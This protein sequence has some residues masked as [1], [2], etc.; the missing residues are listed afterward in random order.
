MRRS[1][2]KKYTSILLICVMLFCMVLQNA[3]AFDISIRSRNNWA[4]ASNATSSNWATASNSDRFTEL[5]H[6]DV[7]MTASALSTGFADGDEVE[8][9]VYLTNR[10]DEVVYNGRLTALHDHVYDEDEEES[11]N[12]FTEIMQLNENGEWEEPEFSEELIGYETIGIT[13]SELLGIGL[14]AG[15]TYRILY[16]YCVEAGKDVAKAD[17]LEFRFRGETDSRKVNANTVLYHNINGWNLMPDQEVYTVMAGQNT[18]ITVNVEGWEELIP[19]EEAVLATASDAT[20][21]NAAAYSAAMMDTLSWHMWADAPLE[22]VEWK[23]NEDGTMT[24]HFYVPEDIAA[25]VYLTEVGAKGV[26]G[27]QLYC[28]TEA[29]VLLVEGRPELM[30]RTYNYEDDEIIVDAELTSFNR[31]ALPIGSELKADRIT[32]EAELAWIA[33]KVQN[34]TGLVYDVAHAYDIRFEF[35]G[36]EIEPVDA[37][38]KVQI[39]YKEALTLNQAAKQAEAEDVKVLHL[40]SEDTVE[41]VTEEIATNTEGDVEAASFETTSFSIFVLTQPPE[42]ANGTF[43]Q[44]EDDSITVTATVD[45]TAGIPE[46][47]QLVLE[48]IGEEDVRYQAAKT[49]LQALAATDENAKTLS[50]GDLLLYDFYFQNVERNKLVLGKDIELR[51]DFVYKTDVELG[52][53]AYGMSKQGVAGEATQ[54]TVPV[55]Q[56]DID[57]KIT[58]VEGTAITDKAAV[59]TTNVRTYGTGIVVTSRAAYPYSEETIFTQGGNYSLYYILNNFN[60]FSKGNVASGHCI[61][62]AAVGGT[63]IFSAGN[64]KDTY[65]HTAPTYLEG[66]IETILDGHM[67]ALYVGEINANGGFTPQGRART[68]ISKDNRYIDFDEAFKQIEA[69]A[70]SLAYSTGTVKVSQ[71]DVETMKKAVSTSAWANDIVREHYTIQYFYGPSRMVGVTVDDG[72]IYEFENLSDIGM[73]NV[74]GNSADANAVFVDKSSGKRKLPQIH[75]KGS[76]TLNGIDGS[77][78]VGEGFG[79][80]FV[81]PNATEIDCSGAWERWI[82]HIVAPNAIVSGMIGD[83]NGATICKEYNNPGTECHMWP[84]KGNIIQDAGVRFELAKQIDGAVPDKEQF[85]FVLQSLSETDDIENAE[86]VLDNVGL[87]LNGSI[88]DRQLNN[89][90]NILF[91]YITYNESGDYYYKVYEVEDLTDTKFNYDSTCYYIKVSVNVTKSTEGTFVKSITTIEEVKCW[92]SSADKVQEIYDQKPQAVGNVVINLMA[93]AIFNNTAKGKVLLPE[94]GGEGTRG[95]LNIS[96]LLFLFGLMGISCS[97]NKKVLG[98]GKK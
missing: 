58:A 50:A 53:E 51:L 83:A 17:T 98:N 45:V 18:E 44:Y 20:P 72:Y 70:T 12:Y 62:P 26:Y 32:D 79:A 76:A 28:A 11:P 89:G 19:D 34:E 36:E 64:G 90:S 31:D 33:A 42:I 92:K 69:E 21:S 35:G 54:V 6:D 82:G 39:R 3:Y 8:I 74:R 93:H 68:F 71:Q 77:I 46:T 43:F 85:S 73:I 97:G 91:K 13:E 38:V 24:V 61:G 66:K 9:A 27:K 95:L 41:D 80:T 22:D 29:N 88:V 7:V 60:I 86:I 78:E 81:L 96:M 15:A 37:S 10:S 75:I 67:K 48:V 49:Q 63:S 84:Y 2:L 55:Y 94:T 5:S 40:T 87:K 14:N 16:T 57:G 59:K 1:V 47:A 56:M 65:S 30:V 25:G 23:N 4:T 52:G